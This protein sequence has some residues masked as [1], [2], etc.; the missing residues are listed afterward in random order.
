MVGWVIIRIQLENLHVDT[1]SQVR[2]HNV[3]YKFRVKEE[4]LTSAVPDKV[5]SGPPGIIG[6]TLVRFASERVIGLARV[7]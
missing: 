3:V 7:Y 6:P 4:V 2:Y 1:L 5:T